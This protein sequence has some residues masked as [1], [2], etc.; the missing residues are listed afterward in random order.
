MGFTLSWDFKPT[1]A[2]HADFSGVFTGDEIQNLSTKHEFHLK[3]EVI[4]GFVKNGKREP[5]LLSLC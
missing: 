5:K 4:D 3:C 1:N 2:I